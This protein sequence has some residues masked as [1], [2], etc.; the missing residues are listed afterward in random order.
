MDPLSGKIVLVTGATS[1]IGLEAAVTLAREGAQ[2]GLVGRD[3]KRTAAAV[4][5]VKQRSRQDR[6]DSFLC[7]FTSQAQIRSLSAAVH[8]R[9]DRLHVLI[10]NAGA[11]YKRRTLTEDGIEA[12]FAVNHLGYFLLTALL[13]DLLEKGA[14]SRVV[15]VASIGHRQGTMDFSDLGFE[16]GYGIMKAYQRSKLGNILFTRELAKRVSAKGITVNS[17]HPGAVATQIWN[18][19]PLWAQPLLAL[20]KRLIMITPEEGGQTLTYLATSPE[21]SQQTGLYFEKNRPKKPAP[22]AEDDALAKRLWDESARLVH[23]TA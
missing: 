14:P 8:A 12:T 23:L 21:V 13:L 9:Y 20:L 16:R 22:L 3:P 11:V 4:L 5:L 18:G 10:N 17:L 19:A 1:G 6:V 2:V 15:N 7:D